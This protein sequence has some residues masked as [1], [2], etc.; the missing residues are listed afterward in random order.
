MNI[1]LVDDSQTMRTIQRRAMGSLEGVAFY[2]AADGI[3]ALEVLSKLTI[4]LA[5]IDWNMP[6]MDGLSLVKKIRETNQTMV[7]IMCTTEAEKPRVLEA[8]KAGVNNYAMKPFT[9]ETLLSKIHQSLE[10]SRVPK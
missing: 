5:L 8:I 10:K 7:L 2:E 1:L 9:P 3:D 4:D 6:R